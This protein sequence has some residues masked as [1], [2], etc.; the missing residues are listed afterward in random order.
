MDSPKSGGQF[1]NLLGKGWRVHRSDKGIRAKGWN[2]AEEGGAAL[3][4][5]GSRLREDVDHVG[6]PGR[7]LV[8]VTGS[9]Q[10]SSELL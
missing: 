9:S 3:G 5:I 10:V 7:F 8:R 1:D 6:T 2:P 4:D